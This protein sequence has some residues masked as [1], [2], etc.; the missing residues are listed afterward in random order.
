MLTKEALKTETLPLMCLCG[1]ICS[2][3]NLFTATTYRP[4]PLSSVLKALGAKWFYCLLSSAIAFWARS[5]NTTY[6]W[7]WNFHQSCVCLC[8]FSPYCV[9]CCLFST[10]FICL[11]DSSV[12][13]LKE[14]PSMSAFAVAIMPPTTWSNSLVLQWHNC[15]TFLNVSWR[16]NCCGVSKCQ[17]K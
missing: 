12:S 4:R 8:H 11:Q 1:Y 17:N 16:S 15:Q 2:C 5:Q 7:P 6:I 3:F 14:N 13:L 9:F 10:L